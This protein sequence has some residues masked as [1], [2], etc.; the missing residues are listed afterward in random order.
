M[1]DHEASGEEGIFNGLVIDKIIADF[2][3][4]LLEKSWYILYRLVYRN[5][6]LELDVP[7]SGTSSFLDSTCRLILD[8]KSRPG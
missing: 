8:Y 7:S 3:C 5:H 1:I 2:T 4:I 6:N